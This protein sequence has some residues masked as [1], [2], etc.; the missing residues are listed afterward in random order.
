MNINPYDTDWESRREVTNSQRTRTLSTMTSATTVS[1]NID[2]VWVCVARWPV[3]LRFCWLLNSSLKKDVKDLYNAH[4]EW[5]T[6]NKKLLFR[7]GFWANFYKIR[8]E[9][10]HVSIL[11]FT[12]FISCNPRWAPLPAMTARRTVPTTPRSTSPGRASSPGRGTRR[13][14]SQAQVR[15]FT[16]FT[17]SIT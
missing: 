1:L 17:S 16:Y 9:F 14:T 3:V 15:Y 11:S 5:R 6:F 4:A 10:E 13:T 8:S 12:L 7:F 2:N